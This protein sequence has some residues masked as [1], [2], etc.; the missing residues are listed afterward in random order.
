MVVMVVAVVMVAR[1]CGGGAGAGGG[2]KRWCDT[3]FG[4]KPRPNPPL[5]LIGKCQVLRIYER[6]DLMLVR[7]LKAGGHSNHSIKHMCGS[8]DLRVARGFSFEHPIAV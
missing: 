1:W 7:N 6:A 3:P 2:G 4:P 8:L 5:T